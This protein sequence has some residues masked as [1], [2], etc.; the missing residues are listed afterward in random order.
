MEYRVFF[1]SYYIRKYLI[2]T[3]RA[4]Y[5]F[6]SKVLERKK[7][8]YI[9]IYTHVIIKKKKKKNNLFRFGTEADF[10]AFAGT[11]LYFDTSRRGGARDP[12]TRVFAR[13]I[14]RARVC[15]TL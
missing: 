4:R 2:G 13:V 7:Y 11:G 8:L 15:V 6:F 14:I 9:Y 1:V 10:F 12:Q 3:Q 5:F